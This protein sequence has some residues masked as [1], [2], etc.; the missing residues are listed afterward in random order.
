[1]R[2]VW[3]VRSRQIARKLAWW[4]AL[5]GYDPHDHS[6]SHR[7]YLVYASIFYSV[8]LFAVFSLF[9]GPAI[10]VLKALSVSSLNQAAATLSTLALLGWGLY[11]LW[12]ATRRSP[13]VFSE[14]DAYQ[15]PV[16]GNAVALAWLLGD[17][18]EP[19]APFWAGAVTLS[20]ALVDFGL[21]HKIGIVDLPAYIAAAL[22]ALLMIS[23]VQIGLM[24]LV[25]AAGALRLQRD[26]QPGWQPGAV[27][28]GIT[29]IGLGLAYILMRQGLGGLSQP[30]W[31][32]ALWPL[33]FPLRAAFG[34]APLSIGLLGGLAW[35]GLGLAALAW[36]G[37]GLNLSRAAQETTQKE[38][39]ET[40]Q[41]Y[42]QSELARQAALTN[43][44]GGGRPPTR[45]PV[46]P[47]WRMVGWKD[48][49]QSSRAFGLSDIWGWLGLFAVG[50]GVCLAPDPGSRGL[51]LAIWAVMVGQRVTARMQKD[52]AGWS[53]LRLLPFS[54]RRLLVAE[55]ALPWALVVL[56]GWVILALAG[57]VWLE[58]IRLPVAL[59]LPCLSASVSFAAAFDI[60]RQ[61]QSD[62]L[63]NG[64][65]PQVS[66][67][68]G[69]LGILCLALPL[70][71]WLGLS[72]LG[73]GGSLLAI[74][75]AVLLALLFWNLA[76]RR[77]QQMK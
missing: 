44:L 48:V 71:L 66:S 60:L 50:L 59:L 16:P 28:L 43:R 56:L 70:G 75:L 18:F 5:I 13:L 35:S 69:L 11:Q 64:I 76:S 47:G 73:I 30:F 8:W 67:V 65:S 15:A 12:Q 31:Q 37:A 38:M 20:I 62:M 25:W 45:L 61:A 1:V 10:T 2:A 68:G 49:L 4:L 21:G 52:L 53:L 9:A 58:S 57:G 42:G 23:V 40:A 19:A 7:I 32:A 24:A 51:A 33:N 72:Q 6:L 27:R 29:V 34:A 17:W 41:R 46:R 3:M 14:N 22:V 26:R 39:I 74:V 77:L 55:L 36:A 63:L 54:S